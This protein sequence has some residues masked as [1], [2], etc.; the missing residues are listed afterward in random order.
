MFPMHPKAA[1]ASAIVVLFLEIWKS[2]VVKFCESVVGGSSSESED[3]LALHEV[4]S[5]KSNGSIFLIAGLSETSV[6]G[7][8][9][10]GN[11]GDSS[12]LE[13]HICDSL[14]DKRDNHFYLCHQSVLVE[15]KPN[16]VQRKALAPKHQG[17]VFF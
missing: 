14:C 17:L 9:A 10:Q 12:Q 5:R 4:S 8:D 13:F 1:T 2:P 6:S 3:D 15:Q 11:G 7:K 16:W